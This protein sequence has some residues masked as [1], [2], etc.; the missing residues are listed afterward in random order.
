[1]VL[2]FEH[3]PEWAHAIKEATIVA[4]QDDGRALD[5]HFRAAAFGHSTDYVLRYD[6]SEA[7]HKISWVL[8]ES[9]VCRKLDGYYEFAPVDGDLARTEVKY[10][11]E[12]ELVVPLPAFIKRRTELK[13]V[14]TALRDLRERIEATAPPA[15]APSAEATAADTERR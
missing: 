1:M 13:I 14:H 3:Y 8:L 11:L 4:R 10:L 5:V 15:G 6:Y 12:A 2:D 7:P 9:D